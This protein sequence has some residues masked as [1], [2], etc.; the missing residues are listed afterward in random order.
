MNFHIG[1]TN[2]N[3]T[4]HFIPFTTIMIDLKVFNF[5]IFWSIKIN[6]KFKNRIL[7]NGT[8]GSENGLSL[9]SDD[10]S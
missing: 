7:Q 8:F 6:A 1:I 9:E 3:D 2:G 10:A 5:Y 4:S